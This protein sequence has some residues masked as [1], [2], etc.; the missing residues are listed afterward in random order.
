MK[1]EEVVLPAWFVLGVAVVLVMMGFVLIPP[2]DAEQ[3]QPPTTSTAPIIDLGDSPLFEAHSPII[4]NYVPC[5]DRELILGETICIDLLLDFPLTYVLCFDVPDDP[6][7]LGRVCGTIGD[8][9][10]ALEAGP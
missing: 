5:A 4:E 9:R 2:D 8:F 3:P 10:A 7:E 1:I 6:D